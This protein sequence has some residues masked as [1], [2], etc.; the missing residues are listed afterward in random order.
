MILI[1]IDIIFAGVRRDPARR[2]CKMV[3][4]LCPGRPG[5]GFKW[6]QNFVLVDRPRA[7]NGIKKAPRAT[8]SRGQMVSNRGLHG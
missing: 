8:R 7:A 2:F 5:P 4:K 1:M 3:S 6:Y